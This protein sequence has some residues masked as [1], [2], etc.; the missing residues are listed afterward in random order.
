MLRYLSLFLTGVEFHRWCIWPL[1]L[2]W[3]QSHWWMCAVSKS[4]Q[5]RLPQMGNP[6]PGSKSVSQVFLCWQIQ[7]KVLFPFHQHSAWEWNANKTEEVHGPKNL[8]RGK[9]AASRKLDTRKFPKGTQFAGSL[10]LWMTGPPC[11][12]S[13]VRWGW[14]PGSRCLQVLPQ[15]TLEFVGNRIEKISDKKLKFPGK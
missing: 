10:S 2:P 12:L 14:L 11:I 7:A 8:I 13:S 9:S 1:A 5:Q 3:I 15:S 4:L 6:M